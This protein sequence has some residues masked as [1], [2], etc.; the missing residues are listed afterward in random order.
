MSI[1]PDARWFT[2]AHHELGHIYYYISYS[3][4]EVPYLLRE[5]ANRAFHEGIGD[6]IGLAAGQ[7]PYLK[8]VGLLTPEAE[9]A[10]PV[11][12]LLDTALDGAS[13]V[14]LPLVGRRDD[15]LRARLLRRHDRRRRAQ[16]L[17]VGR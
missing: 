12:F 3:T 16:R 5:G 6:L 2:T 11:T 14:F 15:P 9:K 10:E 8:E 7:R 1:E 17:L 4:P 13:I